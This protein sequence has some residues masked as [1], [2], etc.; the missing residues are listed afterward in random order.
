VHNQLHWN[1]LKWKQT[2]Y[3][4][5]IN[6]TTTTI[7]RHFRTGWSSNPKNKTL[8]FVHPERHNMIKTKLLINWN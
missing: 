2:L 5:T 6:F 4:L 3:H 1:S 8:L 7:F